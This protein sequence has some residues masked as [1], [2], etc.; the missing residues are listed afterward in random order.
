MIFFQVRFMPEEVLRG[1]TEND[2]YFRNVIFYELVI[3]TWNEMR[4]RRYS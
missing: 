2:R 3:G 4:N 1:F